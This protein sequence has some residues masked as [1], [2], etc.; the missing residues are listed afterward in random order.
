MVRD[1]QDETGSET[2]AFAGRLRALQDALLREE[3]I[4]GVYSRLDASEPLKD[5]FIDGSGN[6][7]FGFVE[8]RV[9]EGFA[10]KDL[11]RIQK[12]LSETAQALGLEA[13]ILGAPAPPC[14][15]R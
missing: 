8:M 15:R 1:L 4:A 12:R 10:Q 11:P 9:D 13:A 7:T 6:V 2:K 14:G 3:A 5:A